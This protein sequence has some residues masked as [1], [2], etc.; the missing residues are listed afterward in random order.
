MESKLQCFC[1]FLNKSFH[2]V[3][4][5][6]SIFH[7]VMIKYFFWKKPFLATI[8]L[9]LSPAV[10]LFNIRPTCGSQ[11]Y[12]RWLVQLFMWDSCTSVSIRDGESRPVSSAHKVTVLGGKVDCL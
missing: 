3:S 8:L 9:F 7:V 1:D 12:C 5:L 10:D 6:Q 2:Y 4:I 11:E